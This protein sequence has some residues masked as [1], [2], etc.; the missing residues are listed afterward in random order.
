MVPLGN[1]QV[2]D[3]IGHTITQ[4]VHVEHAGPDDTWTPACAVD[5]G[6]RSRWRQTTAIKDMQLAA[7]NGIG[8]LCCNFRRRHRRRYPWTVGTRTRDGL[9]ICCKQSLQSLMRRPAHSDAA[10]RSTQAGRNPVIST[11]KHERERTR[12]E[13]SGESRGRWCQVQPKSL[14][15]RWI[16]NE[17]QEW[18]SRWTSLETN[19]RVDGFVIGRSAETVHGFGWVREH[20]ALGKMLQRTAQGRLDFS[21]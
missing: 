1:S 12:P 8:P 10:L 16:A 5:D 3:D 14:D 17:E 18:L 20:L 13:S 4:R 2:T 9:T 11:G 6:C 21:G 19:Q 7:M 15:H